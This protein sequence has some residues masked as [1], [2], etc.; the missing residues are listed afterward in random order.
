MTHHLLSQDLQIDGQIISGPL[1]PS[2]KD[3]VV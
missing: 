2:V 3:L 1:D